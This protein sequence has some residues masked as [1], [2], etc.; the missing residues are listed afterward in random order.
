[1]W[2]AP[3]RGVQRL[4]REAAM[5]TR[6][7]SPSPLGATWDGAGVNFALFSEN[8]QG[9]EL[10]LF[11]ADG[12]E[13]TR[14][15]MSEQTDQVWHVYLPQV[16][17]GPRYGF[18]VHGPYDPQA[19]HRFNP[20]KLVLDPYAK[21]IDVTVNWGDALFGYEVAHPDADLSRD[22]RDSGPAMP[23]SVVTDPAFTWGDDRP[24]RIPL[25]ESMIYEVH[26]KGFSARHPDVPKPL[27]GTY[28][29]LASP[30]AIDYL[31]SLGVTAV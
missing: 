22:D 14:V 1:M 6:P 21:A 23:K 29:G 19:G 27:R 12:E 16:R 15:P 9:V 7:G 25:N 13:E 5:R 17:P 30:A 31:H 10:C 28:A 24:P 8:A 11:D 4:G 26:V 18:R 3:P 2:I 20:A